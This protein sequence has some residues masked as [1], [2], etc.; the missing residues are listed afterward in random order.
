MRF[1]EKK[2]AEDY[3]TRL[4][5]DGYPGNLLE[6]VLE[7]LPSKGTILDVGAGTGFFTIPLAQKGY[8]VTA[9]EPSPEMVKILKQKITQDISENIQ[10]EQTTWQDWQG[11]KAD[12]LLSVHSIYFTGPLEEALPKM[13]NAADKTIIIVRRGDGNKTFAEI[14]RKEFGNGRDKKYTAGQVSS[15]LKTLGIKHDLREVDQKRDSVFS[16]SDEAVEYYMA[17]MKLDK[18]YEN[19]VRELVQEN[20][21]D[22]DGKIRIPG[23]YRDCILT[24]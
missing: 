9:I 3:D 7:E 12:C 19:R 15:A 24:F 2:F 16:D 13:R 4:A 14:L 17:H 23:L 11:K 5:V 1:K 20:G 22:S 8:S 18:A 21:L 6:E 10:V